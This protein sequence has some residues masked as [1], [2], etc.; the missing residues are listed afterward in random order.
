[1]IVLSTEA[2]KCARTSRTT[3]AGC[4]VTVYEHLDGRL[5]IGYGSHI[6][7]RYGADGQ[8]L[9]VSTGNT[10]RKQKPRTQLTNRTADGLQKAD[11][12]MC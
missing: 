10:K 6:V 9:S 12:L 4:R 3:R 1:M 2:P 8:T 7:G 11:I 5:S